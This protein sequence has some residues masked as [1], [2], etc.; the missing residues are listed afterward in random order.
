METLKDI[1]AATLI[2]LALTVGLMAYFDV[3]LK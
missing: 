2:G 1:A 3:L